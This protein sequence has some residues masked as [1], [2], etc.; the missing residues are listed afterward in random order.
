MP[1]GELPVGRDGQ[2]FHVGGLNFGRAGQTARCVGCHVGHSTME[3]P[4]DTRWTNLAPSAEIETS[5]IV[6]FEEGAFRPENL[7]DRSTA[8]RAGDWQAASGIPARIDMA[9]GTTL[10]ARELVLHAPRGEDNQVIGGFFVEF[11]SRG[12][13]VRTLQVR[14]P[15]RPEGTRV[16]LDESVGFQRLRIMI[17]AAD[18]T[19]TYLG[20]PGAALAEIEVIG[21]ATGLTLSGFFTRADVN[22]SR[23]INITDAMAVLQALFEGETT[24]DC[25]AAADIDG[26]DAVELTDAVFLL[27]F[28]YLEGPEPPAPFP[29]CGAGHS[30]RLPCARQSCE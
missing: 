8:P 15:V 16:A 26:N 28:L 20:Q 19:G 21:R 13:Q 14:E 18:V 1:T 11:L 3:V 23:R 10:R 7:V 30:D 22:A 12:V 24:L 4:A 2:V 6:R 27:N 17:S 29:N 5:E 25:E 9:W